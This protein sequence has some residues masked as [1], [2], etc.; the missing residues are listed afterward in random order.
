MQFQ[1]S[2][3]DYFDSTDYINKTENE[4]IRE[5]GNLYIH[6]TVFSNHYQSSAI[7]IGSGYQVLI[8]SCTFHNNSSTQEGG[9][10]HIEI[11]SS[12]LVHIC[13]FD[14][15]SIKWG[16]AYFIMNDRG[17]SYA[18]GCSVSQCGGASAALFHLF[19][20]IQVSNMNTSN[21]VSY[22]HLTLP[23]TERV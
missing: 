4:T 7:G 19:G 9:S 10:I 23:T 15:S 8:E 20:Y 22:T 6:R 5:D 11:S 1:H 13:C 21:P 3:S 14:S 17:K 12:V 18:F 16:C 2:F